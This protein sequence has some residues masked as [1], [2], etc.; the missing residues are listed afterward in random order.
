MVGWGNH[1]QQANAD[2]L[3]SAAPLWTIAVILLL[4]W[5]VGMVS[6]STVGGVLHLLLPLAL[7]ACIVSLIQRER[8][9]S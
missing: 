4:L 5:L 3:K 7:L 1:F 9:D 2:D 6:S 8:A